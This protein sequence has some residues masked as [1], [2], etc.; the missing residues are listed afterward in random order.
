MKRCPRENDYDWAQKRLGIDAARFGD[1]PWVI[2]PRQGCAAFNPIEM[3]NPKTED[4]VG[5]ILAKKYEWGSEIEF[6]DGTGG[7]GG[8]AVDGLRVAKARNV[9]EVQY[10]GKALNPRYLNKRTEMLWECVEWIKHGGALPPI[11]QLARELTTPVY[12]HEGG[13]LRIEEKEQIKKRLG[14]SPN[15]FDALACT[16][17]IPDAPAAMGGM[18]GVFVSAQQQKPQRWHPHDD[19]NDQ[20]DGVERKV[21]L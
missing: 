3:R 13:K 7:Y 17:A 5:R 8:G 19:Q 2:F 18:S 14:F 21:P 15:Y 16:F 20:S 6:M 1:D 10:A 12:W 9:I 11:N 4:V